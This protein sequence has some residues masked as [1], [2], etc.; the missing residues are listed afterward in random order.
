MSDLPAMPYA[1]L[2]GE[3]TVRSVANATR[4]DASELLELAAKIPIRTEVEEF[5]LEEVNQALQRLKQGRIN[6]AAVARVA[7]G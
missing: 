6:G 3:R 2:Y 4:Q 5:P 7:S 1:L